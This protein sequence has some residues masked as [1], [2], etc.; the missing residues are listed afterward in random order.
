MLTLLHVDNVDI[1]TPEQYKSIPHNSPVVDNKFLKLR[2][3][4]SSQFRLGVKVGGDVIDDTMLYSCCCCTLC[5][6]VVD[7]N[8]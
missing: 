2:F 1:M 7:L 8:L 5:C 4:S 3:P 6:Y